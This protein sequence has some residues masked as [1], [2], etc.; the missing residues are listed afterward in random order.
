MVDRL[1]AGNAALVPQEVA[2]ELVLEVPGSASRGAAADTH[3]PDRPCGRAD[4]RLTRP[5][6][7]LGKQLSLR[8]RRVK[9]QGQGPTAVDGPAPGPGEERETSF[10]R[11][12]VTYRSL[13]PQRRSGG[14]TRV[15]RASSL[16]QGD[17]NWE[18]VTVTFGLI[19]QSSRRLEDRIARQ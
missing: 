12:G 4:D 17:G 14:G 5:S 1:S 7:R 11:S 15:R 3:T 2:V 18:E 8:K 19:R 13:P 10:Q 9:P 16:T 6:L